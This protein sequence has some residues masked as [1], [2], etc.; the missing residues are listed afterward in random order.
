M[1]QEQAKEPGFSFQNEEEYICHRLVMCNHYNKDC[2]VRPH[3]CKTALKK[4]RRLKDSL[5]L[6]NNPAERMSFEDI[7]VAKDYFFYV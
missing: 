2:R 1:E 6:G 7:R 4:I 3:Q 5:M